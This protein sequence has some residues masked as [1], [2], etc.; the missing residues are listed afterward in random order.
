M[1]CFNF[2]SL[3]RN[4]LPSFILLLF[5]SPPL[6]IG[7]TSSSYLPSSSSICARC[8]LRQ[9]PIASFYHPRRASLFSFSLVLFFSPPVSPIFVSF[10]IPPPCFSFLHLLLIPLRCYHLY[11]LTLKCRQSSVTQ[12]APACFLC[13][14]LFFVF[15]SFL[16]MRPISFR[17]CT[18]SSP[19]CSFLSSVNCTSSP[20]AA[21]SR[22]R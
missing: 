12:A 20:P 16:P 5:V 9:P 15:F 21:S 13:T 3:W 7:R 18:F 22:R 10:P 19:L 14:F 2:A 1:A 6:S 17:F 4:Y 8:P 11:I